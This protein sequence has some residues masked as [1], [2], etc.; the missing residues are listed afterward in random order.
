[1]WLSRLRRRQGR[2]DGSGHTA[3]VAVRVVKLLTTN[4]ILTTP[5]RLQPF[6]SKRMSR[7]ITVALSG[8]Q[9]DR[10]ARKRS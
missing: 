7:G 2:L 9:P 6:E 10:A 4:Q 3:G 5:T 8:L 1:M